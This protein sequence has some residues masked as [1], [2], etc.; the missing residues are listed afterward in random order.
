M[1]CW[2]RVVDKFIGCKLHMLGSYCPRHLITHESDAWY[3]KW[4]F[5][6]PK[7]RMKTTARYSL[8]NISFWWTRRTLSF[9][10]E[11]IFN[12]GDIIAWRRFEVV[13]FDIIGVKKDSVCF[14]LVAHIV[15]HSTLHVTL[16][17][18]VVVFWSRK[19]SKLLTLQLVCNRV[20]L[21]TTT[22]KTTTKAT[23]T[24]ITTTT[25]KWVAGLTYED[26]KLYVGLTKINTSPT[27]H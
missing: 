18:V 10:I 26:N 22:T 25:T 12:L 11:C 5:W 14:V 9:S 7:H 23:T 8:T 27:S 6:I 19:V 15:S 17:C 16:L 1:Y 2:M 20:I 13:N 4:V 21:K 3:G 24:P